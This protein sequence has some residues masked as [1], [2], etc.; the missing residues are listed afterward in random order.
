MIEW[1]MEIRNEQ[2]T[3]KGII[4]ALKNGYFQVPSIFNLSSP[5]Q[6]DHVNSSGYHQ[7]LS[8]LTLDDWVEIL[9]VFCEQGRVDLITI[10]LHQWPCEKAHWIL[11]AKASTLSTDL[12]YLHSRLW[13][14][15][16]RGRQLQVLNFLNEISSAMATSSA[17]NESMQLLSAQKGYLDVLEWL[18]PRMGSWSPKTLTAAAAHGHL[19]V[20]E[21][22][23]QTGNHG[24]DVV[25]QEQVIKQGQLH[26]L[27]W[28]AKQF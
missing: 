25:D 1:L 9:E 22:L 24:A 19:E 5:E 17:T 14:A 13:K 23:V 2:P 20:L 6:Q 3:S 8:N 21:W 18:S 26:V 28:I 10:V 4:A 15:A 7:S 16:V 12:N 27:K 11:L